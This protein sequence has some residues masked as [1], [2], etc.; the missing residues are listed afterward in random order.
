MLQ[1]RKDQDGQD[2][3]KMTRIKAWIFKENKN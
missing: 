3:G 2:K 1:T